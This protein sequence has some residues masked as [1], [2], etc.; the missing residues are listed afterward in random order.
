MNNPHISPK[1]KFSILTRL[2]KNNKSSSVPPLI[3]DGDTVS[4]SK[5]KADILNQH[6]SSKATVPGENDVPP[7]LCKF[8]VL[9]DL[10]NINTSPLEVSKRL[11]DAK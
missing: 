11:R 1:K 8:N 4:N 5:Q 6:F 2:L 10:N 7:N 3:E 9:S